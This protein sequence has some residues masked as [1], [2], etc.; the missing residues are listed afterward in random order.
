N[1]Q[2]ATGQFTVVDMACLD[3]AAGEQEGH[4][5]FHKSASPYKTEYE[6]ACDAV[7]RE[8]PD[9][10]EGEIHDV[11]RARNPGAWAE[12]KDGTARKLGGNKGTL[13]Q[14]RGQHERSGEAP[15]EPTT[16]RTGRTPPQ[17]HSEHSGSPPTTAARAPERLPDAP[18]VK[19][20]DFIQERTGW[21]RDRC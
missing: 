11:A 12:H 10:K 16:G 17:W 1:D 21:T 19:M 6:A 4:H 8:Y 5:E 7:R 2:I 13:P 14:S 20:L 18:T 15:P 3:R 9:L